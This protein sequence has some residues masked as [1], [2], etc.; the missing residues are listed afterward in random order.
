MQLG[1]LDFVTICN[2]FSLRV[3]AAKFLQ[4][5]FKKKTVI[6][7]LSTQQP[8]LL[9]PS[10]SLVVVVVHLCRDGVAELPK[11]NRAPPKC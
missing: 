2:F 10:P 7:E 6:V 9:L 3:G 5:L 11:Q 4:T 1:G 8:L